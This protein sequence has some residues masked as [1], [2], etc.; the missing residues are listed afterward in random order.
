MYSTAAMGVCDR[1]SGRW[2]F[3]GYDA[4]YSLWRNV[5]AGRLN[6]SL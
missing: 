5:M 2:S 4:V 3:V 6:H 1:D